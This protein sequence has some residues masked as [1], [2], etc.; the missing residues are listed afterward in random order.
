MDPIADLEFFARLVTHGSLSALARDLGVTPPAVSARLNQIERRLGVK[1]LNRTTRRLA[2]TNEGEVYLATGS[3]LLEQVH[4]LERTVSSSRNQPQGL[5]KVNATF[6]FGRRH[7]V[8]ALSA[9][10]DRHPEVEI[11]LELTDRPM[12]L[13]ELAY[14]VGIR[15]GE[16]PDQRVVGRKLASNRRFVCASPAYLKAHGV[17][18]APGDLRSHRCIVLRENDTAYGTWHFTKGKRHELVKV[19]GVM[20]SNDGEATLRWA[21][22]GHGVLVR[23]EWDAQPFID[24]GALTR[25]LA[26]WSLPPS[27]IYAVYPERLNLSAKV[28]VFI[29]FLCEYLERRG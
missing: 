24:S 13:A 17:P 19:H 4:E 10:R 28:R 20:S 15:F 25:V 2:M 3:K 11:Q 6:G 18:K 12:S 7:I 16:L 27:D 29:D 5:L 26:D 21:I 9:F 23:S 14:D 8:P 1:L 22:D